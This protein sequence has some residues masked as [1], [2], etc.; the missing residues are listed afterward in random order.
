MLGYKL[1]EGQNFFLLFKQ[2]VFIYNTEFDDD[3]MSKTCYTNVGGHQVDHERR[4]AMLLQKSCGSRPE[5]V[6]ISCP[7]L[8]CINLP[9]SFTSAP[10]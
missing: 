9:A 10:S 3:Q 2:Y 5:L 1:K 4:S 8:L 7:V 6:L